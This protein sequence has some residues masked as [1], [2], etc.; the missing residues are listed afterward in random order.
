MTSKLELSKYFVCKKKKN[1]AGNIS[2]IYAFL[3]P[4]RCVRFH[5][6]K[7]VTVHSVLD[8]KII[9]VG[10]VNVGRYYGVSAVDATNH[11]EN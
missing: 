3:K 9:S 1:A 7:C 8:L 10:K 4:I 2:F 5:M 11:F 6:L